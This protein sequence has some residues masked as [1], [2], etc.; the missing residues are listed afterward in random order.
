MYRFSNDVLY[1][2]KTQ[3]GRPYLVIMGKNLNELRFSNEIWKF[4]KKMSDGSRVY[5]SNFYGQL[6]IFKKPLNQSFYNFLIEKIDNQK[7]VIKH[8]A[9]ENGFSTEPKRLF[10]GIDKSVIDKYNYFIDYLNDKFDLENLIKKEKDFLNYIDDLGPLVLGEVGNMKFVIPEIPSIYLAPRKWRKITWYINNHFSGP[11]PE[12]Y[13]LNAGHYF[14]WGDLKIHDNYK[15]NYD[16]GL[17]IFLI[18][19]YIIIHE[20]WLKRPKCD[21]LH[22]F[23]DIIIKKN[24]SPWKMLY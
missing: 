2:G 5:F 18:S 20:A 19:R 10:T 8:P 14:T 7:V 6:K 21:S 4:N 23:I 22:K 24:V 13:K 11:Y 3:L 12:S 15:N 16:E 1:T 9:I 17:T